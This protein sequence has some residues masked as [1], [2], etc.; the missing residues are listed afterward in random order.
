LYG[1]KGSKINNVAPGVLFYYTHVSDLVAGPN[2]IQVVQTKALSSG[3]PLTPYFG[4]HQSQV[5]LFNASD[6]TT[7]SLRPTIS[8]GDGQ[9][10]A[11]T[12]NG[13][14]AGQ[15]LIV[16]IKYNPSSVNGTTVDAIR[17]VVHYN[18]VTSLNGT[19]GETDPDGL[20]L[21]PKP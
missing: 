17:P 5:T 10:V 1:V 16:G 13:A 3:G 12:V 20:N 18:F 19:Q 8:V 4:V 21:Q 6:C 2:T 11:I 7:S 9:T 15:D 14:T